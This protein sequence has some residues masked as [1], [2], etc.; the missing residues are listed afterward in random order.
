MGIL[1]SLLRPLR[2]NLTISLLS[3]SVNQVLRT[4]KMIQGGNFDSHSSH[5]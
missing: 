1:A 4:M 2:R 3:F 5:P